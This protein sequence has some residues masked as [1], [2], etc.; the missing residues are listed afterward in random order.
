MLARELGLGLPHIS[1]FKLQADAGRDQRPSNSRN[2]R[3][4]QLEVW[5]INIGQVQSLEPQEPKGDG[6]VC[7]KSST[8][9]NCVWRNERLHGTFMSREPLPFSM[10]IYSLNFPR[11]VNNQTGPC[12]FLIMPRTKM[13]TAMEFSCT[14]NEG[15]K[16]VLAFYTHSPRTDNFIA[17]YWLS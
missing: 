15:E 14:W 8:P 2:I 5:G 16:T 7:L 4:G 6:A 3:N 17:C 13:L 11:R 1:K 10:W 9:P 12:K